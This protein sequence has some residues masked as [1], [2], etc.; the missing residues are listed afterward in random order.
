MA[1]PLEDFQGPTK[2]G[3]IVGPKLIVFKGTRRATGMLR[4]PLIIGRLPASACVF[5]ATA[6]HAQTAPAHPSASLCCSLA[7]RALPR[8]PW[9]PR[10]LLASPR[11]RLHWLVWLV[12]QFDS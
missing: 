3:L 7:C 2:R 12:L 5:P 9:V 4:A 1:A 11:S 6:T 10:A 8:P